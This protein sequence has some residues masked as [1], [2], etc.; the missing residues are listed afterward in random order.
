M[1]KIYRSLAVVIAVMLAAVLCWN[2]AL[3]VDYNVMG[4]AD[5]SGKV[6]ATDARIILRL[7]AKLQDAE[8]AAQTLVCDVDGSGK[9]DATDARLVLRVAAKL[10]SEFPATLPDTPAVTDPTGEPTSET[11]AQPVKPVDPKTDDPASVETTTGSGVIFTD[12]PAEDPTYT[13]G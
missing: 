1:K 3:A 11:G 10:D 8:S 13:V 2:I 7:A 6:D 12:T 5:G 4:D 9:V